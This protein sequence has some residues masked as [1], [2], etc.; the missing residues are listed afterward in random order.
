[1]K[2]VTYQQGEYIDTGCSKANNI[3]LNKFM[4]GSLNHFFL[5]TILNGL[6]FSLYAR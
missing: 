3:I 1:M 6:N 4:S 5:K 2:A